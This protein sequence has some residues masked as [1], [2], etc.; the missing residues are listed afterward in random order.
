M[1]CTI[2]LASAAPH[3]GL[4]QRTSLL[5]SLLQKMLSTAQSTRLPDVP[6]HRRLPTGAARRPA[7]QRPSGQVP[8]RASQLRRRVSVGR[9]LRRDFQPRPQL[10]RPAMPGCRRR[11][12]SRDWTRRSAGVPHDGS[13]STVIVSCSLP[14][15]SADAALRARD[16]LD[17]LT[18]ISSKLD[19]LGERKP[20]PRQAIEYTFKF[21]S[22]YKPKFH[23][24]EFRSDLAPP[25]SGLYRS[26]QLYSEN[27]ISYILI[28]V[29]TL[30]DNFERSYPQKNWPFDL[31]GQ[32][33]SKS[34][35]LIREL[36]PTI[37]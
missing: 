32:G 36:C 9:P 34:N 22:M 17:V 6:R 21:N 28:L 29:A 26:L 2:Q 19:A 30:C 13:S 4:C 31:L 23:F 15:W 14:R 16:C 20:T 11:W 8:V 35:R 3:G 25:T 7:A 33:H 1:F 27:W 24:C 5:L 18:A 10:S 37:P 12:V